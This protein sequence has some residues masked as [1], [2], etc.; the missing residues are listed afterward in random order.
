MITFIYNII[1]KLLLSYRNYYRPYFLIFNYK[2]YSSS[3]EL[4]RSLQGIGSLRNIFSGNRASGKKSTEEPYLPIIANFNILEDDHHVF[5]DKVLGDNFSFLN[6]YLYIS[7]YLFIAS[8]LAFIIIAFSYLLALQNPETEK[9]SAYE[10]GF[11]PYEDARLKFDV[12]FYI[13]AMLLIIFDIEIM[14]LI[15]WS[16]SL[17]TI[18][19]V[20][21][22][23]MVDFVFE[24]SIGFAYVWC[25]GGLDWNKGS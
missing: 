15:P 4:L 18:N 10:C 2:I 14:F 1:I 19:S 23:I 21:Y 24:L 7:I 22:W 12:A 16:V 5:C 13:P 20:G 8:I 9:M 11:E 3:T 6:E 17:S 25:I